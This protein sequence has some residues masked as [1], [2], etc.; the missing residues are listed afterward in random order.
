M[1]LSTPWELSG[2]Y[3]GIVPPLTSDKALKVLVCLVCTTDDVYTAQ[4]NC[5]SG[6][7]A[8]CGHIAVLLLHWEM[9]FTK[10]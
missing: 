2:S 5:V 10:V 1:T 9:L 6:L 4:C 3:I 7:R 8:A